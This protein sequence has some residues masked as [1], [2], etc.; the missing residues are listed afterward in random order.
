MVNSIKITKYMGELEE[1]ELINEVK[2]ALRCQNGE[3]E[4]KKIITACQEG[5]KKVGN[6]F[7]KGKYFIGDLIFA[8]ELMNEVVDIL[9]PYINEYT[10]KS[11]G[12]IVLGT[13]K[14]DLHDIGKNIFKGMAQAAGFE[15]F[16]LGI[17]QSEENFVSA[18][19]KIKPDIVGL[20][21]VLSTAVDSM[22]CTIQAIESN[23]LRQGIKIIIGG[24]CTN[25][26]ICD[27]TGADEYTL[28]A[29]KGVETCI[30]WMNE[31]KMVI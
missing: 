12:R 11:S 30:R 26:Q 22:K 21:G 20:S 27:F 6:L 18:I 3:K 8:G 10:W 16:D 24:S 13:V 1:E 15:V 4:S 25:K 7:E 28:N 29:A 14:G 17:D 5:M 23:D 19:N 2:Q 31:Y 9:K